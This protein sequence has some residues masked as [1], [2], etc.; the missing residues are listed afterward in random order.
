MI[1]VNLLPSETNYLL[2]DVACGCFPHPALPRPIRDP[3][4]SQTVKPNFL[5]F[6]GRSIPF[7]GVSPVKNLHLRATPP[8]IRN[9]AAP[10]ETR[11]GAANAK[12]LPLDWLF[13]LDKSGS[14]ADRVLA[15]L[16]QS[17]AHEGNP[18]LRADYRIAWLTTHFCQTGEAVQCTPHVLA[19]YR[20]LGCHPDQVY[21]RILARR[22]AL[23]G[24]NGLTKSNK[25]ARS[26]AAHSPTAEPAGAE[27]P[28][29]RSAPASPDTERKRA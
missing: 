11:Y 21:Q 16:I 27:R 9:V 1:S 20:V 17:E 10:D 12:Q 19:T 22:Q 14:L 4:R 28:H 13:R 25:F 15:R 5:P 2:S 3:Q 6:E 18:H 23:L 8:P 24:E 26:G 29:P 7:A